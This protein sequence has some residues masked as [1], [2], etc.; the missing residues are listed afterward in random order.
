MLEHILAP[1]R[2]IMPGKP[3]IYDFAVLAH[4]NLGQCAAAFLLHGA[5]GGRLHGEQTASHLR[6]ALAEMGAAELKPAE[7]DKQ[8]VRALA[9]LHAKAGR[10][11][12]ARHRRGVVSR[13]FKWLQAVEAIED[14]PAARVGAPPPP[15][16]RSHVPSAAAVQALWE[17]AERLPA[18][19]GVYVKLAILL[20]LRRQE[21]ANIKIANIVHDGG[22][23][24]IRLAA[25]QTKNKR[26]FVMPVVGTAA[27]L[28]EDL[29]ATVGETCDALIPLARRNRTFTSW[30]HF[31]RQIERE[32]G[33]TFH[34]HDTRRLFA[35]EMGEHRASDF[36]TIDSLLNHARS[37]SMGSGVAR[38]L[39]SRA[40]ASAQT[41]RDGRMG[42]ARRA[43]G[44]H[45]AMA[46]AGGEGRGQCRA[47]HRQG[48]GVVSI[49]REDLFNVKPL[50]EA[51]VRASGAWRL[52]TGRP[53]AFDRAGK[54]RGLFFGFG[55]V[56]GVGE[57]LRH[58][59]YAAAHESADRDAE[60]AP[61]LAGEAA[62]LR[63]LAQF[64]RDVG[65]L[66]FGHE[67]AEQLHTD[68]IGQSLGDDPILGRGIA[69]RNRQQPHS[70]P[71]GAAK[72]LTILKA[73]CYAEINGTSWL[74]EHKKL[75]PDVGLSDDGRVHWKRSV[76]TEQRDLARAVGARIRRE[77]SW[78]EA[79][80]KMMI[81]IYGRDDNQLVA[82][83]GE[84]AQQILIRPRIFFRSPPV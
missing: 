26:P 61:I 39:P 32:T 83:V 13:L 50:F 42:Q 84:A 28:V 49:R 82:G 4:A 58:R 15:A 53:G 9:E 36:F 3:A 37:A 22:E 48:G 74:A 76:P 2:P 44:R 38:S 35:S 24:E 80:R 43:R 55:E 78:S 66:V 72:A 62:Q 5:G 23:I 68:L 47:A 52:G 60:Q 25:G 11:A 73:C 59:M 20:P 19:K 64:M 77:L 45:W 7:L 21:L 81:R 75:V 8:R 46:Q 79:E 33:D 65:P 40:R 63:G 29:L 27:A 34:W 57:A 10:P 18:A 17:A 69:R 31:G 70:L 56:L 12:T 54:L 1:D 67:R 6:R 14:N 41:G 16:P 51:L 30:P 71:E